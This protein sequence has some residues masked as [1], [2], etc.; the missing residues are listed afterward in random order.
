MQALGLLPDNPQAQE[1]VTQKLKDPEPRVLAAAGIEELLNEKTGEVV[2][3]AA[4]AL[5]KF[6]DSAQLDSITR[7]Q[8]SARVRSAA[9]AAI[10]KGM[11][12]LR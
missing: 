4:G 5:V 12:G 10:R 1:F 8:A 11:T 6:N 3:A 7:S 9:A 2:F